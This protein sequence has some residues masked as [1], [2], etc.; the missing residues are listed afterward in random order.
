MVSN[1]RGEDAGNEARLVNVYSTLV[2]LPPLD[3]AHSVV[4]RRDR[5]DAELAQHLE[6]FIGYVASRGDGK[7]NANRYHLMRHLQHVQSHLSLEI[8]AAELPAFARWAER[9]NA[10]L[11]QDDGSVRDPQGAVLIDGEGSVD[12][13][14]RIPYPKDALERKAKSDA[15]LAGRGLEVMPVLPPVFGAAE[16]LWR[17]ADEVAGRAM[18]LMVAANHALCVAEGKQGDLESAHE[19]LPGAFD[20]LSPQEKAFLEKAA[21][22]ESAQ[23]QMVWRFEGLVVLAWALGI[24]PELPSSGQICE[25]GKLIPVLLA[26]GDFRRLSGNRLRPGAEILDALDL[27]FRLHWLVVQARLGRREELSNVIPG[28]VYER[29]F[30]LNWLVRFEDADWDDVTTPT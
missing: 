9:A 18:A 8:A 7:M 19:A 14:A 24:L 4:A 10:V 17:D 3:F 28:V 2:V 22:D 20:H 11:F 23:I 21:P 5:S 12:P 6:G 30:A 26:A 1:A 27:H 15:L 13:A 25:V 16:V 29:H